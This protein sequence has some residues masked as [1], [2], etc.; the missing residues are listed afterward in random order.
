MIHIQM[1]K[2]GEE[3]TQC[4]RKLNVPDPISI[5]LILFYVLIHDRYCIFFIIRLTRR[6]VLF[7]F[8]S[9]SCCISCVR[10]RNCCKIDVFATIHR[11]P[12]TIVSTL[13]RKRRQRNVPPTSLINFEFSQPHTESAMSAYF[14]VET[15]VQEA[16]A[17]D[18]ANPNVSWRDLATMSNVRQERLRNRANGRKS[19]SARDA[20]DLRLD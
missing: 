6:I 20:T 8:L 17:Y 19:R 15:R 12:R 3:T 13:K 14:E 11:D 1:S 10:N 9:S 16:L 7:T 5:M 4:A 18:D 2:V